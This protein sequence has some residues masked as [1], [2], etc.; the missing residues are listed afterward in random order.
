MESRRCFFFVAHLTCCRKL[1]VNWPFKQNK[2]R[3][4]LYLQQT[5]WRGG[6]SN[7]FIY[8][9]SHLYT[10]NLVFAAQRSIC[11]QDSGSSPRSRSFWQR[12]H[13]RLLS[14]GALVSTLHVFRNVSKAYSWNYQPKLLWL[15]SIW[16]DIL[17]SI[18]I[19]TV[20]LLHLLHIADSNLHACEQR[21]T[22][23]S[24]SFVFH[25]FW[26]LGFRSTSKVKTEVLLGHVLSV[27]ISP[28]WFP[29]LL[30]LNPLPMLSSIFHCW[31]LIAKIL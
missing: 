31:I 20:S 9:Y 23:P 7:K 22:L 5:A 1:H 10:N 8:T 3:T 30:A 18:C 26:T 14:E 16:F 13:Q 15:K 28:R 11:L 27:S 24:H 25:F 12:R 2:R 21:V 4:H 6:R 29:C 17:Q 19:C